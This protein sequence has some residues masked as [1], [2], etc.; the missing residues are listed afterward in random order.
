M[1]A[2]WNTGLIAL[3]CV[4]VGTPAVLEICRRRNFH[5]SPGPLKIHAKPIPRLGGMAIATG[6]VF[7]V[8]VESH[9]LTHDL[10]WWL[11]AFGLIWLAGLVDDIRGLPPSLRLVAQ[12]G[13]GAMLWLG[14]W[15][16]PFEIPAVVNFISICLVV[17]L[18][19]NSFNFLDGSDGLAAG[20]TAI[21]AGTYIFVCGTNVQSFEFIVACS[22]LGACVGFLFFNFSPASIFMGDSGS[23][24]LGFCVA[25]LSLDFGTRAAAPP[26][27]TRWLFPF[28]VAAVPIADGIMVVSRR[29]RF[30][31]SPFEGDRCHYYDL[32]LARGWAPRTVALFSYAITGVLCAAALWTLQMRLKPVVILAVI[33]AAGCG[34]AAFYQVFAGRSRRGLEV[35]PARQHELAPR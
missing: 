21:I 30:G 3:F 2:G 18:F 15:R 27:A 20:V 12:I 8:G 25:Y 16:L 13:S 23:T 14:G 6:L 28:L 4:L 10:K 32:L 24:V 11:A 29:V 1:G 9:F 34:L 7:G 19:V 35:K 33:A 31:E 22:L 17:V 26:D 5:D